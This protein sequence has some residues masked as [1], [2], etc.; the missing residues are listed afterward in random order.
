MNTITEVSFDEDSEPTSVN[1]VT[2][3]NAESKMFFL[4]NKIFKIE[5]KWKE[6]KKKES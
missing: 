4:S 1:R 6:K 2:E 5:G 3:K